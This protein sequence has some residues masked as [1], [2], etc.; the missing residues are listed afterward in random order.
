MHLWL[1]SLEETALIQVLDLKESCS[2][3]LK[4]LSLEGSAY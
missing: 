3:L 4:P 2:I 1:L